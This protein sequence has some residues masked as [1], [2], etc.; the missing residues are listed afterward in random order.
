MPESMDKNNNQYCVNALTIDIEDYKCNVWRDWLNL[1]IPPSHAAAANT[2]W[3][4]EK[5]D[6]HNTKAT[7]FI[8][9][10]F[11]KEFPSLV[12]V[13]ADAGHEI[14]V[15]GFYHQQVFKLTREE[16][17]TEVADCKKLLEDII[18]V[19]VIGHRAPAFSVMP[20]TAWALDVLA[21]EGF[22]YDSSV[23][24]IRGRRYGWPGFS[25]DICK[26]DVP[27]GA[28]IIE[29]PM[30]TISLLGM[31]LPVAGGGYIR[32]FP[33]IITKLAIKHLQKQRPVVVYM[34]PYEIELDPDPLDYSNVSPEERRVAAR[35]HKLQL[36]NR[37]TMPQ[38]I[39]NLLSNFNFAP[40][41]QIID[42]G[43]LN[44]K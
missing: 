17:R 8:L 44:N 23:F 9:G 7:C 24:P 34:H 6:Q 31:S 2:E 11:A 39:C 19:A 1:T 20:K 40:I 4:L 22:K 38:K 27:S 10:E 15:H 16:F 28:S 30:A 13:I 42:S 26:I 35:F 12:K 25:K 33:Y 41:A 14:G 5:L 37:K 32:H 43:N 21:E 36:R 3:F 18:S 29:V